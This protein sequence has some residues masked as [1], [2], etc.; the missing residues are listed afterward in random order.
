[1]TGSAAKWGPDQ[2]MDFRA[3]TSGSDKGIF[4]VYLLVNERRLTFELKLDFDR[5]RASYRTTYGG[6]IQDGFSPP[7]ELRRVFSPEFVELYVFDGELA[8]RLLNAEQTKAQQALD[9]NFS[10]RYFGG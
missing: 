1:L 3:V 10:F 8:N 2:L 5:R 6:N 9:A 7:I 4:I